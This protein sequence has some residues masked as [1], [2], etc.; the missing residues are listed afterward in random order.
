M[1]SRQRKQSLINFPAAFGFGGVALK[2]FSSVRCSLFG[3]QVLCLCQNTGASHFPI[4]TALYCPPGEK[5][6]FRWCRR[7][8]SS[9]STTA[10]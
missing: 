1:R 9:L 7:I 2:W 5:W 4:F 10:T 8:G 3:P 6:Q